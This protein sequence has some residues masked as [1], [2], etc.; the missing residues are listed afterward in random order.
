MQGKNKYESCEKL[1]K[2]E[3]EVLI[4]FCMSINL[5]GINGYQ[6]Q[7]ILKTLQKLRII[8]NERE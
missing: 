1:T 6:F 7:E 8:A 4:K 5:N 2:N 3:V